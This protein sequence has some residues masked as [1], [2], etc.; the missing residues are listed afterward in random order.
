MSDWDKFIE[1]HLAK[2]STEISCGELDCTNACIE[3][4]KWAWDI[5]QKKIVDYQQTII[6]LNKRIAISEH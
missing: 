5:Q 2:A 3:V 4:A 1:D 6:L